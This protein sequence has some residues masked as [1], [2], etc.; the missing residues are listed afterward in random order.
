M[1]RKMYLFFSIISVLFIAGCGKKST[2]TC[3]GNQDIGSA[4]LETEMKLTFEKDYLKKTETTMSVEFPEESPADA[5]AKTYTDK[6]D[7]NGK[8]IYTVEKNGN[9]VVVKSVNDTSDDKVEEN[10]KDTVREYLEKKGFT[11][12]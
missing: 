5:F 7:E 3:T 2:M 6:K 4:K 8:D 12:K 10:K 1:K 9:K 11:C